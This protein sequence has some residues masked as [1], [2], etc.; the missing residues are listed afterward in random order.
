M[1]GKGWKEVDE[2][3]KG[4]KEGV[5]GT[6]DPKEVGNFGYSTSGSFG[7]CFGRV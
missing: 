1:Y 4:P 5:A 2:M 3:G 6:A 7:K